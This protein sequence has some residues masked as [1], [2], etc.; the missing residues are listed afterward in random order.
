M[1]IVITGGAGFIGYNLTRNLLES[2]DRVVVLDNFINS[3]SKIIEPFYAHHNFSFKNINL[4]NI[5]EY[6]DALQEFNDVHSIW[7][8][9]ANSDIQAGLIN[10]R[11][12]LDNTFMTTFNTLEI[13]KKKNV[14]EFFFASTSAVYGDHGDNLLTE[15]MG[16]LSPISNYG[17]LK[18]SSELLIRANLESCPSLLHIYIFRF[19]N[20]I[21]FPATHGLIYDLINKL[22]INHK[23]LTVLGDG[24]QSKSYLHVTDLIDAM[25]YIKN[26]QKNKLNIFNIGPADLL[27][28]VGDIAKEVVS[29]VSPDADIL[30]GNDKRG[31]IGD[32][33][34]VNLSS[35]KLYSIGWL[36]KFTSEQAISKAISEIVRQD[37]IL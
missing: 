25:F 34:K 17:A 4:C 28:S 14:K 7:H 37:N 16:G 3:S 19:P 13:A 23:K 33:P 32:V 31:W 36:P 18:L 8:L 5:H 35:K 1:T 9:A 30:F 2:G 6:E 29:V 10:P 22:K 20:V 11:I 26:T 24:S 21:G 15:E 27:I 12:D